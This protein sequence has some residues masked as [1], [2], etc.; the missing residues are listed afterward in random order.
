SRRKV[1]SAGHGSSWRR[2]RSG[3]TPSAGSSADPSLLVG[4]SPGYPTSRAFLRL[5]T[6]R[7]LLGLVTAH[8]LFA[9]QPGASSRK[10]GRVVITYW[11]KWAGDD[12]AAMQR[13]VDDFNSTDGKRKGIYVTSGHWSVAVVHRRSTTTSDCSPRRRRRC[14]KRGWIRTGRPVR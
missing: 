6:D 1:R 10:D 11:E 2:C 7:S 8:L 14:R 9:V 5:A 3:W 4:L 13:I 12:A